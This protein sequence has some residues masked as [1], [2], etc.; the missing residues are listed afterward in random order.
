[1]DEILATANLGSGR[2]IHVATLARQTIV[3]A[4][5]DHLGFDGYFVFEEDNN[6]E[7]KGS[8]GAR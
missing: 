2:S 4:G 7:I 6:P 5:A 8:L 1:M 3:Q